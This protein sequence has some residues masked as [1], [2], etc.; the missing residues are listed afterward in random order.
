M[1]E[2]NNISLIKFKRTIIILNYQL[3]SL[4]NNIAGEIHKTSFMVFIGTFKFV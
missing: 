3:L 2:G 1:T 4:N